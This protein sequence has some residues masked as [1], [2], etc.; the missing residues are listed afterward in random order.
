MH[1]ECTFEAIDILS[2]SLGDA[3]VYLA[4]AACKHVSLNAM[5]E[6]LS[7]P[8]DGNLAAAACQRLGEALKIF[9]LIEDQAKESTEVV[10]D[11]HRI[12]SR[13]IGAQRGQAGFD[14]SPPILCTR[15]DPVS[16]SNTVSAVLGRIDI[17]DSQI[18]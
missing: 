6:L 13:F 2:P 15:G 1:P 7:G 17:Q 14:A 5:T 9:R 12:T 3:G 16:L 8:H 11:A 18:S 4:D 10:E